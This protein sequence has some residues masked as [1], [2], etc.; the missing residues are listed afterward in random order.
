MRGSQPPAAHRCQHIPYV[1]GGGHGTRPG[2]TGGGY[3]CS[4]FVRY[5]YYRAFGVDFRGGTADNLLHSGRFVRTSHPVPGDLAFFNYEGGSYAD[6][7]GV[8]IGGGQMVNAPH[9][10]ANVG[11]KSF[12]FGLLGYY[13]YRGATAADSVSTLPTRTTIAISSTNV[14]PGQR[15]II[16]G[17][18]TVGGLALAGARLYLYQRTRSSS[19]AL[20]ATSVTDSTGKIHIGV[21]GS[22]AAHYYQLRML[23]SSKYQASASSAPLQKINFYLNGIASGLTSRMKANSVAAISGMASRALRGQVIRVQRVTRSGWVATG[24]ATVVQASGA[25]KV[26]MRMPAVVGGYVFRLQVS[27]RRTST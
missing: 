5:L 15:S 3:D 9:T 16:T 7:V 6:H 10:G 22:S 11:I 25:Y 13:H 27:A 12:G 14:R 17:S 18:L 23:A 8:Y 26:F 20:G 4:G 24:A 2:A 1:Y 21:T 19:W